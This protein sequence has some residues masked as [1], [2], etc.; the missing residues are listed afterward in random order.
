M[1]RV[2]VE[3]GGDIFEVADYRSHAD[4]VDV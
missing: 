4:G 1:L 2:S 3:R